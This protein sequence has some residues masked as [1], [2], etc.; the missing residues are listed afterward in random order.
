[1]DFIVYGNAF[2]GNPEAASVQV[3]EDG[4][5]W[6]ELAGSLY[7]DPNTLRDVN[8]T[9][10]LSG[11]DIQYSITDPN[12]R[13]PGVSFPLT[14]TFKAGAAAWFP[15]TANYGGVW[16]TSAVSSDQT[17]GASA[18]NGASVT[19]TGVTLV[20]DTD[21]TADYQFGYADIHVNGGNYGHGDRSLHRRGHHA[22]WGWLRHC[23]GGKAGRHTCGAYKDRLYPGIYIRTDEQHG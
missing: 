15:T 9:Y 13:N 17:V 12:G 23:V 2:N 21:T 19:Y 11:S 5:T 14:G 6:Y 3:S 10:T 18:F 4:K 16:K 1:M 22:G 20:K 8:I 7:Y